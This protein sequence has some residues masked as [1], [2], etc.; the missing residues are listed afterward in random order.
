MP[1]VLPSD[2][3]NRDQ[4]ERFVIAAERRRFQRRRVQ[5]NIHAP[6]SRVAKI[7]C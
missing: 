3:E 1:Q 5:I 7:S 6:Q 2:V 4:M